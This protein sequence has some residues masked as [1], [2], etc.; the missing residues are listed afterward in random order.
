MLFNREKSR[1]INADR[2]LKGRDKRPFDVP[3]CQ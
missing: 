1:M 2:A 3:V